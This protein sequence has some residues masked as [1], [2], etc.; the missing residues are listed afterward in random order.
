M[1]FKVIRFTAN[2]GKTEAL[3]ASEWAVE[4]SSITEAQ[5]MVLDKEFDT[6]ITEMEVREY[7]NLKVKVD[8]GK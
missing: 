3:I 2:P 5:G 8:N 7:P 6:V 1:I 4:A